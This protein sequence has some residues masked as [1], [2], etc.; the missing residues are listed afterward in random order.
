MSLFNQ[1]FT[2]ISSQFGMPL[3]GVGGLAFTGNYFWVDQTNGSDGNTG[4]PQDPFK[5]L[6]QAHSVCLSG[7]NDVVF[8]TGTVHTTATIAWTKNNTHLIGLSAPSDNN[9]S[10]ISQTGSTV[11]TPLVN[12]TGSG[13]IFKNIA[14]FHGFNDAS[15]QICWVEDGGR[16]YYENVQFLGM[17]HATAAAEAGSRSLTVAGDGENLFM[18]CT[19]GLDTIVRATAANASLEF[20][21]A[22]PR[23][24]L[25]NC[26]FQADVSLATDTH[27]TVGV[28]GIDRFV[29]LDNCTF[30]NAEFG[31]PGATAMTAALSVSASAGG[32]VLMQ[33]GAVIGAGAVSAAGPVFVSGAVPSGATSSLAVL[34]S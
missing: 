21:S 6:A 18:G 26:L 20:L 7:N 11:F 28:G 30:L 17:G 22:T 1:S 3:Y 2:N 23:N 13:C 12:V 5:T 15:T 24:I 34:A 32:L 14:T 27:I 19:I 4:G 10:R 25:R 9:R 33:G 8:L 29:L 31:G 16:N